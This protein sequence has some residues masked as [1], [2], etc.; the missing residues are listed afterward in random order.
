MTKSER[1]KSPKRLKKIH[2]KKVIFFT[3]FLASEPP[4]NFSLAEAKP[5]VVKNQLKKRVLER[6][7]LKLNFKTKNQIFHVQVKSV[8]ARNLQFY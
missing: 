1:K 2:T 6:L 8:K 4:K 3:A 5:Q 7:R